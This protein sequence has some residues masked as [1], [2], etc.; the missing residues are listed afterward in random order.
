MG[1]IVPVTDTASTI[2]TTA[3][4]SKIYF[5]ATS[6]TPIADNRRVA[7]WGAELVSAYF[8]DAD[9]TEDWGDVSGV[10][11]CAW[12]AN[13]TA[14]T[15]AANVGSQ[16]SIRFTTGAT[17][18]KGWCHALVRGRGRFTS[19]TDEAS[20]AKG[21]A[22]Y[23]MPRNSIF[24]SHRNATPD[25]VA[26]SR[27]TGKLGMR[28]QVFPFEIGSTSDRWKSESS[29]LCRGIVAVAW[30]ASGATT[31]SRVAVTQ[32]AAGDVIF[33]AEDAGGLGWLWVW[34]RH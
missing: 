8:A 13:G 4:R 16:T 2:Y 12:Q 28:F 9:T 32:D 27:A 21:T 31:A 30:Q 19:A 10:I 3:N 11:A 7:P 6:S 29:G 25:T 33:T 14:D 17:N 34:R 26:S 22:G 23:V 15:V 24:M 1:D 18:P 20:V 5:D